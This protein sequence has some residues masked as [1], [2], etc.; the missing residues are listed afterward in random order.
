M[1][2]GNDKTPKP[3]EDDEWQIGQLG[4]FSKN[5]RDLTTARDKHK[6]GGN[7]GAA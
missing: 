6:I 1:R 5:E 7:R 3:E 2:P 4:R